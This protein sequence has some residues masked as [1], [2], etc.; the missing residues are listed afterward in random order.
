MRKG[1]RVV[2]TAAVNLSPHTLLLKGERGRVVDNTPEGLDVRMDATHPG[3]AQWDNCA[4]LV[5]PEL[6]V[7]G[8]YQSRAFYRMAAAFTVGVLL[9]VTLPSLA[10]ATD[11][12]SLWPF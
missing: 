8:I 4:L 7:V 12:L 9:G 2:L 5:P 6:D 11:A 3:L 10:T 1:T